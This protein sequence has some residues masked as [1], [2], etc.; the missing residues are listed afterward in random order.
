MPLLVTVLAVAALTIASYAIG[1]LLA[2][3]VLVPV[4][5]TAAAFP[6]MFVELRR[7]RLRRAVVT[8]LVWAL[9]M[10]VAATALSYLRPAASERLF[11]NGEAYRREM[12]TWVATGVGAESTPRLFIP[13]HAL[14]AAIFCA[15]S[16][17]TGSV[18]SM[19]MGAV[20]MNYMGHY[21]GALAAASVR[22]MLTACLAWVPWA[23]IRVA[24]F[25]VLG[26]VLAGPVLSRA[27][28]FSF[29]L[30]DHAALLALGVCGLL[31]DIAIKAMLAPWWQRMLRGVVGW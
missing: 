1:W 4:L 12:F 24:S 6:F 21:V 11:I 10:G 29:R 16:L 9:A 8:M 28:R 5:N 7:G 18:L 25:V 20:L 2:V 19:P 23:V 31:V 22:P 30:R 15:L 14:H 17:L 26:V 13:S 3:P 27:G